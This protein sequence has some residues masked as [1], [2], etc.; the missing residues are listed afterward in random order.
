MALKRCQEHFFKGIFLDMCA[1][2][3]KPR[4]YGGDSSMYPLGEYARD[5]SQPWEKLA[6]GLH[7]A[8]KRHSFRTHSHLTRQ[9][10]LFS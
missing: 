3:G 8:L 5:D 7:A 9:L 2:V 10:A 6:V 4:A 1:G